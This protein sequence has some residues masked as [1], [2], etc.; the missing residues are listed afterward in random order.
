MTL[1][2]ST[3][4]STQVLEESQHVTEA[5]DVQEKTVASLQRTVTDLSAFVSDLDR[6]TAKYYA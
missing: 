2:E 5:M 4:A 1:R 3:V 6:M